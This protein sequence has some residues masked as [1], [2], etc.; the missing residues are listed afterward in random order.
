MAGGGIKGGQVVGSSDENGEMPKDRP[1]SVYDIHATIA[2]CAGYDPNKQN[3]SP[4]GRPIRVVDPA[5]APINEA[6]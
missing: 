5:A 3:E 4:L 2:H 6:L 1:I